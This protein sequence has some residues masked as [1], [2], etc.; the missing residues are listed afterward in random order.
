MGLSSRWKYLT[1]VLRT[2]PGDLT[3]DRL[4]IIFPLHIAK[5]W[6]AG[7]ARF[8]S[9]WKIWVEQKWS[10]PSQANIKSP[11][12]IVLFLLD[13]SWVCTPRQESISC[14]GPA[15][16]N[17]E[18]R[19][20]WCLLLP[21]PTPTPSFQNYYLLMRWR[22]SF[23]FHIRTSF[24]NDG[25]IKLWQQRTTVFGALDNALKCLRY[26]RPFFHSGQMGDNTGEMCAVNTV[27]T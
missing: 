21:L 15:M 26:G 25:H 10:L 4:G 7:Y 24:G 1:F 13:Q 22:L 14:H 19:P 23:E 5:N 11:H 3:W 20:A 27:C 12:V 17:D 8:G 2:L 16:P 18:F 6:T 9:T